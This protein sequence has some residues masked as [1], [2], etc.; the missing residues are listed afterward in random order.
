VGDA[1]GIVSRLRAYADGG[2]S[3]FVL[4]PLARGD[5]DLALQTRRL[6]EEV[7]PEIE[8]APAGAAM[9]RG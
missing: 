1:A 2:V 4:I 5:D 6:V 3:K 9:A 8:A 7:I